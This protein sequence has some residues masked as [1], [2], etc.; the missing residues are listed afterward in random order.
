MEGDSQPA[1]KTISLIMLTI[2]IR[3]S[4]LKGYGNIPFP[5]VF[6]SAKKHQE[7]PSID[8]EAGEP[9]DLERLFQSMSP[10]I[11]DQTIAER[12][13]ESMGRALGLE[14][15][16]IPADLLNSLNTLREQLTSREPPA[17]QEGRVPP[18]GE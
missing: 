12:M 8:D 5:E 14:S 1:I 17:L 2:Y 16:K 7:E 10:R 11:S 9:G 13:V 3:F 4:A 6:M 18:S 15:D